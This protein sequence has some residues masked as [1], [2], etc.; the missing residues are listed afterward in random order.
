MSELLE[1]YQWNLEGWDGM[2]KWLAVSCGALDVG[3]VLSIGPSTHIVYEDDDGNELVPN[4]QFQ[5]LQDEVVWLRRSTTFMYAPLL[6][7]LSTAG[8]SLDEWRDGRLFDDCTDGYIASADFRVL[9]EACV[10][11]FRDR[12][13]IDLE[14]LGCHHDRARSLREE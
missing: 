3:D 8:L 14:D 4:A 5:K 13:E 10:S 6:S 12:Q 11:W 1:G 2:T 7:D 9:A